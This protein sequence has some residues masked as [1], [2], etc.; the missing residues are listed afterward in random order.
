M[1]NAKITV[2]ASSKVHWPHCVSPAQI[3]HRRG[4]LSASPSCIIW[5]RR[6]TRVVRASPREALLFDISIYFCT[7][8]GNKSYRFGHRDMGPKT[9]TARH[10]TLRHQTLRSDSLVAA[11]R[12]L[13][14]ATAPSL[15]ALFSGI[16]N[17]QMS[18]EILKKREKFL[19]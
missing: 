16:Y 2:H 6:P 15:G 13:R 8:C 5:S 18:K 1:I 12:A 11:E 14:H 4:G 17:T 7:Y 19:R 9:E 3:I 10:Q